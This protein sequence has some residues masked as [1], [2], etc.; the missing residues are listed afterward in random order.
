MR[1]LLVVISLLCFTICDSQ[2][3]SS[4]LGDPIVKYT[5]GSGMDTYGPA[6][7]TSITN[8]TYLKD[9]CPQGSDLG[10]YAIVHSPG[11]NCFPPDWLNFT[12]DHTGDSNGYFMLINASTPP[13]TFYTQE[14]DGLCSGTS[15]QFSAWIINL[16]SHS[17][18]INPNITFNIKNT[19]GT[20][21]KSFDT[22]PVPILSPARWNQYAFYF[23]TPPGVNSVIISMRNNAPGGYGNDLGLDDITFRTSGP[24][25]DISMDGR[26]GDTATLCAGPANTLSFT[27]TVGNCYTSNSYQWQE[28]TDGGNT[29]TSVPGAVM[30]TYSAF[31]TSAGAYLFRLA[32]AQT[33]NIGL[34]A[35]QVV[36]RADSVVVLNT[37]DPSVSIML[38][39]GYACSDSTAAFSATSSNTGT[40]PEYQWMVNS[41]PLATGG[42]TY[43]TAGLVSGDQV[44]CRVTS[45]ALCSNPSY[46]MSNTITMTLLPNVVSSVSIIP[47]AEAICQHS[48]V[49]FT[50]SA[51]NGGSMPSYQWYLNGNQVG[52]DTPFYRSGNLEQ[53][54]QI[55]L[56]MTS[57][58]QCSG[59]SFSNVIRMTVYDLPSVYLPADTLIS[60]GSQITLDP[61]VIGQIDHYQWQPAMYMNDPGRLQP[62]VSPLQT[63]AYQITV[64]NSHCTATAAEKVEV[65][66]DL[67]MPNAFT[68][69]GDGHNDLYRVPHSRPL[70]IE[71]FSIYDRWGRRVFSTGDGSQGWDGKWAGQDQ[72]A[73]T[74]VWVI[75]YYHPI[76]KQKMMKKGTM[77]L[78]R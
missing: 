33:G 52:N 78:I 23:A 4:G 20:L 14:I 15:Y 67:V 73:G 50:A 42:P 34:T 7:P 3:C 62:I 40:L 74:Y 76:L 60:A 39:N 8:M 18:E 32:A 53:G 16:A 55:M 61:L 30:T 77:L 25:V 41:S 65:F 47:S 31:P 29:W 57:T 1:I 51:S 22:G 19:D 69:N 27:G 75:E 6:L 59:P 64:D 70:I 37:V 2:V 35:C 5:F 28:S 43:S 63:T 21:I 58:L 24:S 54:D 12:G 48:L 13:S 66:Y 68:P 17:G 49:T 44:N 45:N 46:A 72:P 26:T 38:N 10:S 56:M 36:S 9:S 71:Q 11:F